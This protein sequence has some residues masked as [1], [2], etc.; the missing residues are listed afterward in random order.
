[1]NFSAK[2]REE[3][4]IG[5]SLSEILSGSKKKNEMHLPLEYQQPKTCASQLKSIFYSSLYYF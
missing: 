1:M 4:N 2:K 5:N 3:F